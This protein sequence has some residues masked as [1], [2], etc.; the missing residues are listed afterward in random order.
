MSTR[1]SHES[2]VAPS[3]YGAPAKAQER[4]RLERAVELG[5]WLASGPAQQR[6]KGHISRFALSLA[7]L[8][9][10]AAA[11]R[12][13]ERRLT[14]GQVVQEVV[15]PL[16]AKD[17]CRFAEWD[18][19]VADG[20]STAMSTMATAT[21]TNASTDTPGAVADG[22]RFFFASHCWS[23]VFVETLAMLGHHFQPAQQRQWRRDAAT[24]RPLPPLAPDQVYIW[25][26]VFAI[27]QHVESCQQAADMGALAG[28]IADCEEVL[29]VLDHTGSPLTRIWCLWEAW[30]ASSAAAAA[31]NKGGGPAEQRRGSGGDGGEGGDA[32]L[33]TAVALTQ[34][35]GAGKLR[36]LS[37]DIP[38]EHLEQ[39]FIHLDVGAAQAT[40]AADRERILAAITA[41]CGL[42]PMGHTL[43][44]AL[45]D[46]AVGQV[47]REFLTLAADGGGGAGGGAAAEAGAAEAAEFTAAIWMRIDT[48]GRLAHLYGR[49]EMAEALFRC[50]LAGC[51][52]SLGSDHQH[53]LT[54]RA[55]LAVLLE[56][57]GSIRTCAR[58]TC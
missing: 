28:V 55:N 47:P 52:R 51:E 16:T 58:P 42:G 5:A 24:G 44:A 17:R 49:L 43:K 27:N 26:D 1:K 41:D 25:L 21:A 2:G 48:A 37:Y 57:L 6:P 45:V 46:G 20:G 54:S 11:H 53:G 38:F 39:V 33:P 15:K 34:A 7:W 50:A 3:G 12:L 8:N 31:G 32:Q 30:T 4:T 56:A 40:V 14:T 36:L 18:P 9:G 22:R 10:F 29:M 19:R 23:G 35:G 13:G